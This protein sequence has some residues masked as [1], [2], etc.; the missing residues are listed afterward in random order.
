VRIGISA[1]IEISVHREEVYTRNKEK[2]RR[3]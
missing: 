3:N 1:P 2:N